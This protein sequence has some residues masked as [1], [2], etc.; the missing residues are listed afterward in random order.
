MCAAIARLMQRVDGNCGPAAVATSV[1]K[2][3]RLL[4]VC[5]SLCG[6]EHWG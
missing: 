3:G 2:V 5:A 6:K 4:P 1:P